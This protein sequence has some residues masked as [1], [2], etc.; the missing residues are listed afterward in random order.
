[1]AEWNVE[2]ALNHHAGCSIYDDGACTC[3]FQAHRTEPERSPLAPGEGT[4]SV[5]AEKMM[6]ERDAARAELEVA[7]AFHDVAVK[8]RDRN[9]FTARTIGA[10]LAE[11][12]RLCGI[13]DDEYPLKAVRRVV[14]ER[15]ELARALRGLLLSR[16]AAW[17]GGHDWEE[18]VKQ[19]VSALGIEPE[20]E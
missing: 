11:I 3:G 17:T 16:D 18:A 15:N 8:E 1:M 4:W 19:A 10:D 20:G 14:D 5:F 13:K 6:A 9:L 7:K 2:T 12:G